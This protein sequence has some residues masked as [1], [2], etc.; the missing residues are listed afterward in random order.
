MSKMTLLQFLFSKLSVHMRQYNLPCFQCVSHD[1]NTATTLLCHM[2]HVTCHTSEQITEQV[3]LMLG[4]A[5]RGSI[6]QGQ[7]D[8]NSILYS[9]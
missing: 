3:Q 5:S 2:S 8:M 4:E 7:T 1:T 9:S 6:G